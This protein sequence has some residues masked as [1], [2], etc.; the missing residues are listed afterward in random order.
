MFGKQ[1]KRTFPVGMTLVAAVVLTGCGLIQQRLSAN[2]KDFAPSGTIIISRAIDHEVPAIF[3]ATDADKNTAFAPLIGYSPPSQG[4]LPADNEAWLMVDTQTRSMV[5]YRGD[6][7]VRSMQ[8]EGEI[9]LKPGVY[10][11]QHKQKQP[12][13]Y[14][15]DGYFQKRQLDIPSPDAQARY[16]RGALGEYAMYL[17]NSFPIHSS[18]I[19]STDVGGIKVARSEL[20]SMY[21]ML[22]VGSTVVIK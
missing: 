7:N 1:I 9:A 6:E 3:S 16:R 5:L 11:L 10:S 13:W 12:L 20:S 18:P 8:V 4:F 2:S 21:Y 19:W 14:A 17:T 22:P 15:P